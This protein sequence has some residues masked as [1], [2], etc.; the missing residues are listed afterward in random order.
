MPSSPLVRRT[1]LLSV[2][3]ALAATAALALSPVATSSAAAPPA[4]PSPP[5]PKTVDVRLINVN[6]FHGN[7]RPPAGS[8]GPGHAG[9]R[10][11]RR[12]RRRRLPRDARPPAARARSR[13]SPGRW[14]RATSSAPRRSRSALFHDEPTIEVL[15]SLGLQ[16]SAVGNHEFDEGYSRAAAAC[17]S[18]AATP[19][20]AASSVSNLPTAPLFPYLGANVTFWP[21][22]CRR[23]CPSAI[24]RDRGRRLSA[25]S[26]PPSKDLP[27]GRHPGGREGAALRRRGAGR[28][29]GVSKLLDRLGVR[30]PGRARAPGRQHRRHG[31]PRLRATWSPR[32]HRQRDRAGASSPSVDAI[33]TGHS[34]Q[35]LRLHAAPTRRATPRPVMQGAS[36][37]RL[38]SVVD[39]TIDT[40]TRDVVRFGDHLAPTRSS[41]LDRHPR[42][43]GA[44]DRRPG[45]TTLSAPIANRQVGTLYRRPRG[46]PP[47]LQR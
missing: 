23:C 24:E 8:V 1:R 38:L 28:S 34:H 4:Q 40:R 36:F 32:R 12:R 25:S 7:L 27:V 9:R 15:E 10:L 6:D 14:P 37:G 22:A 2:A 30:R 20:T 43:G 39:L 31:R 33:F 35:A 44:G 21:T 16:A 17:S 13:T 19:P 5:A 41:T 29:T 18:A 26:A 42:S 45:A 46:A 3:A 11:H 47:P